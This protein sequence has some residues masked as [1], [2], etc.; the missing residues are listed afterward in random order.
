VK[1]LT[2][3]AVLARRSVFHT[4]RQPAALIPSLLF[5]LLFMAV[6]TAGAGRIDSLPGFRENI[7]RSYIDFYVAGAL[8]QGTL[9]G[10]IGAGTALAVDIEE[11]F[12]RR[13]LLTPLQR[14]AVL[15]AAGAG[16]MVVGAVQ[17]SV[18]LVGGVIGGVHIAT[19]VMGGVV[20]IGLAMLAAL[21]FSSLG[22][23][24]A[25]WTGSSEATQTF[26]PFFFVMM[27]FS[28]YF[29]PRD[30]LS[31]WF[32]AVATYNP[33]TYIIEA[34]RSP[35]T[36]GWTFTP[37]LKGLVAIAAICAVGFGAGATLLRTRLART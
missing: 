36:T 1:L 32:K 35:I 23:F 21:A 15:I 27:I 20:V 13:L 2:Q 8:M 4:F 31:G 26:F 11:G 30:Y 12:I 34:M 22:T 28:S 6:T 16:A 17:A 18:L 9:F 3:T 5:P 14:P 19:G 7:A 10:G 25:A 29:M 24:I 37:I 33:A